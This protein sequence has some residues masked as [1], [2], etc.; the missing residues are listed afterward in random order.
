VQ[1]RH[2]D[3]PY[4][5]WECFFPLIYVRHSNYFMHVFINTPN[6]MNPALHTKSCLLK[7]FDYRPT[8]ATP[9]EIILFHKILKFAE[10]T[11]LNKEIDE[12]V[13]F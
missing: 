10:I 9:I 12:K 1:T 2:Q 5:F 8:W 6:L 3:M 11:N 4:E 7:A 13:H